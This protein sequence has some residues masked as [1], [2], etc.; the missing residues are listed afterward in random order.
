MVFNAFTAVAVMAMVVSAAPA[1][2]VSYPGSPVVYKTANNVP[3][4]TATTLAAPAA[5]DVVSKAERDDSC[6]DSNT[7][8]GQILTLLLLRIPTTPI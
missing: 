3:T 6:V 1:P 8:L 4:V 5:T 2:Y 7:K